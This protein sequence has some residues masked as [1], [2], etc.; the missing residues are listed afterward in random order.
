M[1]SNTE[2]TK[3][4]PTST[5]EVRQFGWEE[6]D[7]I[8]FTGDA[9]IDHPSFGAAVIGRILEAEGLKVAI[10]PQPNWK[11]DLR[12]F[13]KLGKPRLFF[14]VTGGNMDSMVNHYTAGK[15]KRSTDAYTPGGKAGFRPDYATIVYSKI[16]KELFPDAPLIIGGI[17]ASL[18]RVTHYDY[19]SDKLMPS[20][21]IDS[22]A[23]MLF[24]GMGEKSITDFAR[25]VQKGVPI[26]TLTSIPQTSFLVDT[27]EDY[28]TKK[29]WDEFELASHEECLNDRRKFARNF[30]Y[31][32]EESNKM[33]ARKL[34]QQVG[35][36]KVVVN[37][38][39]P[40]FN[41]SEIDRVYDLPYT[42]LPHPRYQNKEIIPAYEMIRHSINIHRGCFGGCTF[43]TISAHQGKFIASRSEKSILK[44]VEKVTEMPDFKGYISDL[45]G[46]SANMYKM[47]GIH[48]EICRKCK[49][50][51][52]I[53]P[54][55]CKNLD[56]S[57]KP[58][59]DLYE[60]VRMNPKIKKAFVGSGIRYD[61]ILEPTGNK[62]TDEAN[63]KYL[64]EV[65]KHHVSGRL[66][67][68]PEHSSDEVLKF[69]RKPS[70]TLFEKLNDE[71]NKINKEENLNQQLIPY[72]I[73]SHPGSKSEDMADLAIKTK[74]MNFRLEQVQD[75]TPT[76]MTLATVVYYSGYHPYT[77][78]KIYTAKNRHDK[79]TQRQF[80]FWYKNEFKSSIKKELEKKGRTDLTKKLFK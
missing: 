21:L 56:T 28:A 52:C 8:L 20:I 40:T 41:E 23:D 55:I 74:N 50:P 22:G 73:S 12:D 48:E 64:R 78:E 71:F 34:T 31:I 11:D 5:K 45:G 80:F 7:V 76:P 1:G 59:L 15:R 19:W 3:W 30:M 75:F 26:N 6:L 24:Y 47:K 14:A 79:E 67:V 70:F 43:C 53:F 58:M 63:K 42:R 44:E 62:E 25:L 46:P 29:S 39:W 27:D 10:V 60:K 38:P 61:M 16:L 77:M 66:K 4:L 2:I 35:A 49:R 65:V 33:E 13:K 37:P 69:M 68:A 32:E 9:Y 36:K 54:S 18:R 17:E 51:S 72:F 57:H